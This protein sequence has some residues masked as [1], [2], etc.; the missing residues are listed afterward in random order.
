M[1]TWGEQ[2]LH[3]TTLPPLLPPSSG[4]L[5]KS[6]TSGPL[7]PLLPLTLPSTLQHLTPVTKGVPSAEKTEAKNLDCP[8][9]GQ[10]DTAS[11]GK[12]TG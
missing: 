11:D 5:P 10:G 4:P 12:N 1:G 9:G 2:L 6:P 8:N 3:L 7:H